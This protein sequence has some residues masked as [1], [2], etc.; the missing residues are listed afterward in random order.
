[1]ATKLTGAR[2]NIKDVLNGVG[3][4]GNYQKVGE[5]L[6]QETTF[7]RDAPAVE[8]TNATYDEYTVRDT[9]PSS[10][11]VRGNKRRQ[12]SKSSKRQETAQIE[13]RSIPYKIDVEVLKKAPNQEQFL[14]DEME[15]EMQGIVQDFDTQMLYG[16][17][18]VD[19]MLGL[20]PR[21][22]S[23]TNFVVSNGTTVA[24]E[25]LTSLYI[26]AWDAASGVSMVYGRGS[27]AGVSF[28]DKGVVKSWDDV[29][30]YI[31]YATQE[32]MVSGGLRVK[33][34]QAI[35]RIANI[36]MNGFD[37]TTFD[38]DT[39]IKLLA[40][41]PARFRNKLKAYASRN[42]QAAIAMR[43]NAKSNAFYTKGEIFNTE[44]PMISGVPI[45]LDEQIVEDEDRVA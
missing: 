9:L 29:A 37:N 45:F 23:L 8:A 13:T 39:M 15:A 40:Q 10:S 33:D 11:I 38:E 36:N 19:E 22:D 24:E 1:M 18:N 12:A 32:V 21:M 35:G 28:D 4:D 42:L 44:V 7:F 31:E 43:A 3:Y 26:V 14:R 34:S 2:G 5:I 17:G 30:G 25:E 6:Y 16:S 41:F 20:A 27:K